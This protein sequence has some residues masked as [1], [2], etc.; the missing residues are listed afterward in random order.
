MTRT[1]ASLRPR[2]G[3]AALFVLVTSLAATAAGD[4]GLMVERATGSARD[5]GAAFL[6]RPYGCHEPKA[7]RLSATIEGLVDGRRQSQPIRLRNVSEG[8]YAVDRSWP[9]EGAW[10]LA[11]TGT[12]RGATR[13]VLVP[14][15]PSND[16]S[17]KLVV[18]NLRSAP[19]AE[20]IADVLGG[21]AQ[22]TSTAA[23]RTR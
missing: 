15:G 6:V 18:R 19:S 22:G 11:I 2:L 5:T 7:A 10:V 21:L 13:G 12:Y 17:G 9:A 3:L 1:L 20:D 16:A 8:V 23:S 14:L 4:F